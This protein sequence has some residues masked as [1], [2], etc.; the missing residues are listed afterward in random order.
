MLSD[1]I[2]TC[3]SSATQRTPTQRRAT[4]PNRKH[5]WSRAGALTGSFAIGVTFMRHATTE[6]RSERYI[7]ASH[8]D[9][10][11][12]RAL[13][14]CVPPDGAAVRALQLCVTPRRSGG[15]S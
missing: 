13:H 8:H 1:G 9:G 11:A 3:D 12:V 14:L 10:A 6:R 5:V 15:P 7:Y 4:R 2:S